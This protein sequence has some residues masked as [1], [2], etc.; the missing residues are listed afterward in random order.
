MRN[1]HVFCIVAVIFISVLRNGSQATKSSTGISFGDLQELFVAVDKIVDNPDEF[2]DKVKQE[3]EKENITLRT[4]NFPD[5]PQLR[6]LGIGSIFD[7]V[8]DTV[9]GIFNWGSSVVP[10]ESIKNV[11]TRVLIIL[12]GPNTKANI[13]G[14]AHTITYVIHL[15]LNIFF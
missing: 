13:A 15:V 6:F 4:L 7:K 8:K 2:F 10:F 12:L 1:L 3:L 5:S 14:L 9:S 11:V